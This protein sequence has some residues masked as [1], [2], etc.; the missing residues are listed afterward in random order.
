MLG[1]GEPFKKIKKL[2]PPRNKVC[3]S[4]DYVA[5]AVCYE[6]FKFNLT[7]NAGAKCL[8]SSIS[9]HIEVSSSIAFS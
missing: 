2:W 6:S 5:I 1:L 4:C 7:D 3:L 8:F 9:N